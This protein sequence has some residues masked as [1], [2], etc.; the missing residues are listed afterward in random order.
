MSTLHSS[1]SLRSYRQRDIRLTASSRHLDTLKGCHQYSISGF[2]LARSMGCGVRL[3]SDYFDVAG[4]LWRIEVYPSGCT[5]DSRKHV[6]IFLTTPGSYAANQILHEV[7][8]LDQSGKGQHIIQSR[9]RERGPLLASRGVGP[10]QEGDK[11]L[12]G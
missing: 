5:P 6:S 2:S 11:M 1:N 9:P 10:V 3:C 8:I 7:A 4:Q 12:G